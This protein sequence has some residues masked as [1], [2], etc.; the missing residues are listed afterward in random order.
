MG[1]RAILGMNDHA[2]HA[3]VLGI[4]S[5]AGYLGVKSILLFIYRR[6]SCRRSLWAA[7]VFKNASYED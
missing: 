4:I 5:S 1:A 7:A 6:H 2:Y 3:D